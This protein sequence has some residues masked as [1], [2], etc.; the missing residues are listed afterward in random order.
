MLSFESFVNSEECTTMIIWQ[1]LLGVFESF[2]NS[3]ECK[4]GDRM[5]LDKQRF[6]SFVNSE[7]CKTGR[8]Y[9]ESISKFESFVN[10]E[11]C[12][13]FVSPAL[14]EVSLRALLIQK[15]VKQMLD[16]L[17]SRDV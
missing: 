11:E 12:K 4:T 14:Q 2:V 3:E 17:S 1:R 15:S 8:K 10:S 9:Y 5:A 6:E 16:D 13:T 7:E